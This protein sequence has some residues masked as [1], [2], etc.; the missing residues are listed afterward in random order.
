[1]AGVFI[2][3][4]RSDASGWAGRLWDHLVAA[5]GSDLVFRDIDTLPPGTEFDTYIGEAV[6]SCD[7]L[8]AIISPGWL[9]ATEE[10]KRRLDD[11][12]DLLWKELVTALQLGKRVVPALVGGTRPPSIAELPDD[13][14]PLARRQA[15]ELSERRWAEDCR[16][17]ADFISPLLGSS[18]SNLVTAKA[19]LTDAVRG[20]EHLDQGRLALTLLGE[21]TKGVERFDAV[22]SALQRKVR[23]ARTPDSIALLTRSLKKA[24]ILVTA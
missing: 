5:F 9:S 16:L 12:S 17:L 15:Y 19:R 2:S 21:H 13:L 1:M 23:E 18:R 11:P 22:K 10:G 3:Y 7:V 6:T 4:R 14:K 20:L 8:I 24:G